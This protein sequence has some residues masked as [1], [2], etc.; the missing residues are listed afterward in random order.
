MTAGA[1]ALATYRRAWEPHTVLDPHALEMLH[2]LRRHGLGVGLLPN[3][4]WPTGWHAEIFERDGVLGYIDAAVYSSELPWTKP[5][6]D[7]FAAAVARLSAASADRCA[8]VGDRAFEDVYGAQRAGMRT[9][10]VP[11]SS[12]PEEELGAYGAVP[13]A[14]V[15]TLQD[16]LTVVD[17]WNRPGC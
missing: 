3:T 4:L 15:G 11:H 8:F 14:V 17:E 2:G 7:I 13:D 12:I 1:R 10:L 5:H 16:V 6:P 9:I